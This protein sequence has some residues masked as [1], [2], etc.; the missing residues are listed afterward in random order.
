MAT[1]FVSSSHAAAAPAV[2]DAE[3][4]VTAE[5]EADSAAEVAVGAVADLA[6]VAAA[7]TGNPATRVVPTTDVSFPD[8][9]HLVRISIPL[10]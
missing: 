6:A 3:A 5:E 1:S 9:L 8:S 10:N 4:V 2:A 7:A